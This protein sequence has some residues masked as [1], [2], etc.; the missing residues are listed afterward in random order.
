M[1]VI[2]LLL[3]LQSSGKYSLAQSYLNDLPFLLDIF[4][5]IVYNLE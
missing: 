1:N 3:P 2:N 5:S 4:L